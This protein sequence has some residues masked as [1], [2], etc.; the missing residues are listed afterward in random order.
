MIGEPR[1]RLS[2][3][4]EPEPIGVRK[5]SQSD[6]SYPSVPGLMSNSSSTTEKSRSSDSCARAATSGTL[7]A[8]L[9]CDGP[10]A[11][12]TLPFVSA[13][14]EVGSPLN[15]RAAVGTGLPDSRAYVVDHGDS[16]DVSYCT[17]AAVS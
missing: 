5:V 6:R 1:S 4:G 7:T 3:S 8:M 12:E 13:G 17:T 10:A 9:T 15:C 14:A 16:T 2:A 11:S